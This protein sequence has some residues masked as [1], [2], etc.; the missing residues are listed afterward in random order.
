MPAD[1]FDELFGDRWRKLN[2][3]LE[4]IAGDESEA[5]RWERRMGRD[6]AK[7]ATEDMPIIQDPALGRY[8]IGI[9]SH[10][11]SRL[12]NKSWRFCFRPV[13]STL[14]NAVALPGGFILVTRPILDLCEWDQDEVAF[15]LAHEMGHVVRRHAKQRLVNSSLASLAATASPARGL[16]DLAVRKLVEKFVVGSYSRKREFEADGFA[17]ALVKRAGFNPLGATRF[18]NRLFDESGIVENIEN[19]FSFFMDH[20]PTK[21]RI[22][23]I[24]E[25][26][27]EPN[28]RKEKD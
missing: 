19:Y 16:V 23:R 6:I 14:P 11:A 9:G 12:K 25:T 21:E 27:E 4:E 2:W 17:V 5:I 18:L 3:V 15:I 10:L 28:R 1:F 26:L 7:A 20:P 13:D 8:L 22:A 24:Q